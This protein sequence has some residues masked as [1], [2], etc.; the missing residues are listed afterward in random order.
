[1]KAIV[2]LADGDTYTELSGCSI[3]VITDE[4]AEKLADGEISVRAL[5]PISEIHL[6]EVI[7]Q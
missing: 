3:C 5:E 2:V 6:K 1:M 4:D 7:L